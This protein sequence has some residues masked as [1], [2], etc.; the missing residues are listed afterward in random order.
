MTVTIPE[1]VPA[2]GNVKAVF[3]PTL[4][5]TSAPSAAELNGGTDISC[6]LMPDWDGPT[7]TQNTG[8][9]RRFCSRQTFTRLGRVTWSIAPLTYTYDPQAT[10]GTANDVYDALAE[11]NEGFLVVGYGIDAAADFA[12][13]DKVDVFPVE[14]GVQVKA[15]RGTDEFAP[16]TVTQTLAVTGVPNLDA[17]A[18]A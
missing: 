13:S 3:V 7:A 14:A 15:A 8:D 16:L 17:V 12:S 9:D 10:T 1:S 4:T 2:E 6:Y 11:G 18:A 5:S